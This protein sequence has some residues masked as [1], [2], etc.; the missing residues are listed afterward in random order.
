MGRGF[1]QPGGASCSAAAQRGNS[2]QTVQS[3]WAFLSPP[4]HCISLLLD[5]QKKQSHIP[6]RDSKLTKL[7]AD[8]LGGRG[9]T[10]MVSYGV[11]E[12]VV[13]LSPKGRVFPQTHSGAGLSRLP[14]C[15]LQCS[16]FLRLSALCDMQAEL[17]GSPP[18]RRVP[19]CEVTDSQGWL[20]S[21][22]ES[23]IGSELGFGLEF[24]E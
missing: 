15:P 9:V 13:G 3:L 2:A 4:G 22:L 17:S 5:P 16:A 7:L 1:P 11:G 24:W 14:A 6:F 12:L 10:L 8:S 21:W 20:P 23:S 19:R 18:G